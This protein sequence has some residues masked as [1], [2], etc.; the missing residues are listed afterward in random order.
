MHKPNN[1]KKKRK[2]ALN[3]PGL[4]ILML[5][6]TDFTEVWVSGPVNSNLHDEYTD[7]NK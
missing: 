1:L 7:W 2:G 3:L 4:K 5:F 6:V